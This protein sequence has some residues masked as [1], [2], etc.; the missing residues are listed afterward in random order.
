MSVAPD[1]LDEL[2]DSLPILAKLL[3]ETV[4]WVHP[5]VF[6]AMPL[7]YP[8]TARGE[9]EFNAAYDKQRMLNG[10]LRAEANIFAG[11][12]LMKAMG[13]R[14]RPP[15]WAVCHIWGYDDPKFGSKGNVVRDR[16]FYSCVGNMVLV[17]SPLKGLTDHIPE[18]RLMLRTCAYH[19]YGWLC[20]HDDLSSSNDLEQIRQGL[21]PKDYPADWPVKKSD[22]LPRN[23]M[24]PDN[25]VW[26]EIGKRK[27]RIKSEL[28][29]CGALYPREAI[30]S[31]LRFWKVDWI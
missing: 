3:G 1:G 28:K 6:R 2:R 13:L 22:V 26:N 7:W 24:H 5:D 10:N 12:A 23:V 31:A 17:P 27:E 21:I 11:R 29:T 30:V 9:P 25:W 18:V 20:E 14:K 4:R 16:R 8:E 15:N 19:L